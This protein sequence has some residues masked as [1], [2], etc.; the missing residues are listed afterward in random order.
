MAHLPHWLR[1]VILRH[2]ATPNEEDVFFWR[3]GR[4]HV[5]YY[6]FPLTY[7]YFTRLAENFTPIGA[8]AQKLQLID[9]H[10][11]KDNFWFGCFWRKN[12]LKMRQLAQFHAIF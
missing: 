9:K 12:A 10:T 4:R 2:E 8:V 1:R 3:T 5:A 11:Q 6:I 7:H